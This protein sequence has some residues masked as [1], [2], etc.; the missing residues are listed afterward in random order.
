MSERTRISSGKR[1]NTKQIMYLIDTNVISEAR[2]RA[3]AN[4]GVPQ[5]FR[6]VIKE[7]TPVFL[8]SATPSAH[9]AQRRWAHRTALEALVHGHH[10]LAELLQIVPHLRIDH[11]LSLNLL[12]AGVDTAGNQ[13]H[14]EPHQ[15]G[16]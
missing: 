8:S 12:T 5:F 13:M 6:R 15:H 4:R 10:G 3:R 16:A 9:Q 1:T 14:V 11:F 7:R 2:K